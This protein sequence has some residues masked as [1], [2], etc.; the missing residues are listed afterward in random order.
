[1]PDSGW[2]P[3]AQAAPD[4]EVLE[5]VS[6]RD[7]AASWRADLGIDTGTAFA[8]LREFRLC[9][10]PATGRVFFDPPV[11]GAAELYRRLRRFHWYR[12]AHK[13][14]HASAAQWI[15]A[16]ARVLDIGAGDGRFAA[17]VPQ[18]RYKGL[19]TDAAAVAAARARGLEVEAATP[20]RLARG[21]GTFDVVTAFQVLEHVAD[22]FGFAAA[23]VDCLADGGLLI[24]GVPD[25]ESYLADLPDFVLNAPPHHVTWW[26][27]AALRH[28]ARDLG[29]EVVSV[30]RFAVEPWE[31]RLWW[32]A[33][34][35]RALAPGRRRRF[36]RRLRPLKVAAWL[37]AGVL[38]RLPVRTR[39]PS[40]ATLLL[41]AKRP[42]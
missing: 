42:H 5:T 10:D 19:E 26:T 34:V 16:G 8:G 23:A 18:A 4:I 36:G 11:T 7:L 14:E 39:A 32:M 13:A 3:V 28:L 38:A 41:V 6:A 30:A 1:M 21:A 31:R 15:P 25:G 2:A 20:S 9:R 40:G 37:L 33:R 22:P 12:P 35:A 24:L 27:E 17:H 29:L